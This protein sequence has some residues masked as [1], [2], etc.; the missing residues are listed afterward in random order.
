MGLVLCALP[1]GAEASSFNGHD[2]VY[3]QMN[4][5]RFEFFKNALI[6]MST[7]GELK[8][9]EDLKK[10]VGKYFLHE[11]TADA[12]MSPEELTEEEKLQITEEVEK[13]F[14]RLDLMYVQY[15]LLYAFFPL[16]VHS[17]TQGTISF[18]HC[19]WMLAHIDE[20]IGFC[21]R[22]N[23]PVNYRRAI[24]FQNVL[25]AIHNSEGS[26]LFLG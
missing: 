18:R 10:Y 17:D 11:E 8:N 20:F 24:E 23:D 22:R 2:S 25:I 9:D 1:K 19:E 5:A 4:Q 13:S 12:I 14:D 3:V 16:L 21:K 26:L 7:K 15:P 6:F